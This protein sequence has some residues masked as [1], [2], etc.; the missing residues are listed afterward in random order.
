M[1]FSFLRDAMGTGQP[2]EKKQCKGSFGSC[3]GDGFPTWSAPYALH[4]VGNA[5]AWF[6][7]WFNAFVTVTLGIGL[8]SF[9]VR[10][11]GIPFAPRVLSLAAA[12]LP[13][14]WFTANSQ[15]S[16]HGS[17]AFGQKCI[18]FLAMVLGESLNYPLEKR[19]R[20]RFLA[21]FQ[22][23]GSAHADAVGREGGGRAPAGRRP[24]LR[25]GLRRKSCAAPPPAAHR[26]H[27]GPP[28]GDATGPHTLAPRPR[29]P[30]PGPAARGALPR[31]LGP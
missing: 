29:S 5:V 12:T 4:G 8:S 11:I 3:F 28:D 30:A 20:R 26:C 16:Q 14:F 2:T 6:C 31:P 24:S 19:W 22:G 10:R 13:F 23:S 7:E 15:S 25:Y 17:D 9:A 1:E 27:A 18:G 21:T